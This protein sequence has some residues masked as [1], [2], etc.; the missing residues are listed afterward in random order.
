MA[1]GT[2]IEW[3]TLKPEG[4]RIITKRG[5]V[6]VLCKAHPNAKSKG[7]VYEHRLVVENHLQR[8]LRTDECV[9]HKNGD[10][11]DN[12]LC[13]LE[14]LTNSQHMKLH[15]DEMSIDEKRRRAEI[16]ATAAR[17]R[18]APRYMVGCACGCGQEFEHLDNKGR[19]RRFVHGHNQR[20]KARRCSHG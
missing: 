9:H 10:R 13:N 17:K 1:D 8:F 15:N 11:S 19:R 20:G 18:R 4:P 14:V 16:M 6:L 7:H 3:A 2:A 12:R 5:Y